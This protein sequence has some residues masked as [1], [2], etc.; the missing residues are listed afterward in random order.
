MKCL[1][2]RLYRKSG[3]GGRHT[4][5]DGKTIRGSGKPGEHKA[6]RLKQ[7]RQAAFLKKPVRF[8]FG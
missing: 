4:G 1:Q 5:I 2:D 8:P 7:L 3:S 6:V